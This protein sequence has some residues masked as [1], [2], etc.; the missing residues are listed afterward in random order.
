MAT[1][2]AA[3]RRDPTAP[4]RPFRA[5]VDIADVVD[6]EIWQGD[7]R[8]ISVSGMSV[9]SALVPEIGEHLACRFRLEDGQKVE[10]RA[11]VVWAREGGA[12]DGAFGVRFTALDDAA[13]EALTKASPAP[14]PPPPRP[15]SSAPSRRTARSAS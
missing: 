13:R 1:T 12:R 10:S 6:Q 11:E 4:R 3:D 8:D 14:R 9:R 7:A 15:P 5:S 2:A